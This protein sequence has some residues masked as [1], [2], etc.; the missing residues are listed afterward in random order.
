MQLV[1]PGLRL[2]SC[3]PRPKNR[4]IPLESQTVLVLK[5]N[6]NEFAGVK[7]CEIL[8]NI[9]AMGRPT[10]PSHQPA[11]CQQCP[12]SAPDPLRVFRVWP[13]GRILGFLGFGPSREKK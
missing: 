5:H 12:S 13:L 4:N 2:M 9:L 8:R 3:S 6:K 1:Q 11:V 10:P 7:P